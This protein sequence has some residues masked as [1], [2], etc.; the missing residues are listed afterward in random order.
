MFGTGWYQAFWYGI[1]YQAFGTFWIPRFSNLLI[2]SQCDLISISKN[3]GELIS[4]F[5]MSS[6]QS[7]QNVSCKALFRVSYFEIHIEIVRNFSES[8][9]RFLRDF[10]EISSTWNHAKCD[11]IRFRSRISL[12]EL[13]VDLNRTS[14]DLNRSDACAVHLNHYTVYVIQEGIHCPYAHRGA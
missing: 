3:L 4:R 9:T 14:V 5:S 1:W 13:L 8:S 6:T 7:R 12:F 11:S 10:S 2:P